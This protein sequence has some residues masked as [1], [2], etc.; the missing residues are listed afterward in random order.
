MT[1]EREPRAGGEPGRFL[2]RPAERGLGN[3]TPPPR[4]SLASRPGWAGVDQ[5]APEAPEDPG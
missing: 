2:E 1:H 5:G 4:R 3:R